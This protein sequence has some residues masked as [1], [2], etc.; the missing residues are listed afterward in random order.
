[1]AERR[2]FSKTIIDSDLFLD[3]SLSTQCLYF[4]LSMRADD[5]GFVNNPKKIQ[6][7][8]GAGDDELKMLIVKKFI[9]PFE[10][11]IC[12]IKHWRIHNYIQKDRYHPTLCQN[13]FAQLVL[14]KSKN[15]QLK[16]EKITMDT[17]CI[18]EG[19]NMDTQS[20]LGKDRLDKDSLG[21]VSLS[22]EED[23]IRDNCEDSNINGLDGDSNNQNH[24]IS[25][26]NNPNIISNNIYS[27]SKDES[28]SKGNSEKDNNSKS[29]TNNKKKK[30]TK[31]EDFKFK[32]KD[33]EEAF[34]EIWSLYPNKKGIAKA[35][36]RINKLL[37]RISKDELIRC[38]QR[39]KAECIKEK[40]ENKYIQQGSTFFN[41]P[42]ED[43]LDCNYEE[44]ISLS[45]DESVKR[46]KEVEF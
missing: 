5:D 28:D 44:I 36:E 29:N 2:M 41:G 12:V 18:Q 39:Y 11:G 24:N 13:E 4:H 31:S 23:K 33:H 17:N 34:K 40:R 21:K 8:I 30:N 25:I 6:R 46:S 32:S 35:R 15:Y 43:Y 14:D 9:I 26:Y 1:M 7:M 20:S 16:T 42:Y 19:Y 27:S 3:M 45:V 37:D 38:V 22:S 10:S